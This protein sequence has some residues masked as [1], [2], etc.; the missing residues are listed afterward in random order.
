MFLFFNILKAY[1]L[2]KETNERKTYAEA[3]QRKRLTVNTSDKHRI[4]RS[5]STIKK[6]KIYI[7]APKG[8]IKAPLLP[9]PRQKYQNENS[10]SCEC[11]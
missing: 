4:K 7:Q 6:P 10:K 8:W 9:P 3:L 5:I 2:K 1:D 11:V